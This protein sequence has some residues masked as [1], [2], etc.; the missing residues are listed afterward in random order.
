MKNDKSKHLNLLIDQALREFPLEPVP[1]RL[2]AKIMGQI[3]KPLITTRFKISWFDVALSGALALVIGFALDFF[4]GLTRSPYWST[5]L[6][7]TFSLF[8]RDFRYFLIHNQSPVLAVV[9]S[10]TVVLTLLA[11]LASVYWRY[12]VYSDRLPA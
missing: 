11:I 12:T 4:Q 6:Q 2:T 8:W 10:S 1:E 9:L 3:E 7:I 5:R